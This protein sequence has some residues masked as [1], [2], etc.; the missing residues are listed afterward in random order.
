[1]GDL[2]AHIGAYLDAPVTWEKS[3]QFAVFYVVAVAISYWRQVR[4]NA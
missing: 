3:L 1:M 4:E 2:L